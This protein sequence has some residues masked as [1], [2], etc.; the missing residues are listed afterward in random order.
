MRYTRQSGLELPPRAALNAV[1]HFQGRRKFGERQ[2]SGV[3]SHAL[4]S[5]H[6]P[7]Q[8]SFPLTVYTL[9]LSLLSEEE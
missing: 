8:P 3:Y 4:Q 5:Q 1:L 9:W 2:T 6:L 7:L